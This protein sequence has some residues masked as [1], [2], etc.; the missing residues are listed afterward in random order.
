MFYELATKVGN[1]EQTGGAGAWAAKQILVA[2]L[3]LP[4][5]TKKMRFVI[6]NWNRQ[7]TSIIQL[8]E[9]VFM[10]CSTFFARFY[11]FFM[12]QNRQNTALHFTA[13]VRQGFFFLYELCG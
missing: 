1:G 5:T 11:E 13:E 7:Q 9:G 8:C 2:R 12:S 6:M 4:R 10:S 3:Q